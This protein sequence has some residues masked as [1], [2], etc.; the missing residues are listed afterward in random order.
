M[1]VCKVDRDKLLKSNSSCC[2]LVAKTGNKFA[3]ISDKVDRV[4][5]KIDS[6]G[7]S[8]LCRQCVPGFKSS[9]IDESASKYMH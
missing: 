7:D 2:R 1:Y 4:G 5:N 6:I 9:E 8:R 3:H